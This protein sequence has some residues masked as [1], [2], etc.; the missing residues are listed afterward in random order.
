MVY[1]V[2]RFRRSTDVIIDEVHWYPFFSILYAPKK[3]VL[4]VCEVA[5]R[6]LFRLLPYPAALLARLIEKLYFL[7][8]HNASV[9]AISDSTRD[10]LLA[11][12][13]GSGQITVIPM[14]LSLPKRIKRYPKSSQLTIIIIGRLHAFKG[15]ADAIDAFAAIHARV[16]GAILW[17]V[18][19]DSE[20]YQSDLERRVG[21]LGV[22]GNV[23]FFGR[24]SE[25][26]KFELLARSHILLMPSVHEGW[27][28]VVAEAASQ[29][30]PAVGYRTA[31]V[32]DVIVDGKTGILVPACNPK[33][34][35]A[36]TVKLWEDKR[37]Y[38]KFQEA[39]KKRA[40]AMSW[41]D[42]ARAALT[43]IKKVNEKA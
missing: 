38:K 4:L 39:G 35:A 27:G 2:F 1:Y 37:L 33:P 26:K 7:L 22:S 15:T 43:A 24:V 3:T 12:G 20:G 30:T 8:Y 6:L 36:Q 17:V 14:G 31:G 34:L 41:D 25:E 32:Q 21:E 10:A 42:T 23:T 28:L 11:E 16:P 40:A 5:N 19:G 29:E 18:G 13:F 9:L